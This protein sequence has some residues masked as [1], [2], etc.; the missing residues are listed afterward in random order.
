MNHVVLISEDPKFR[1][2]VERFLAWK[3][4]EVK[5]YNK[6]TEIENWEVIENSIAIVSEYQ[7]AD[8]DGFSF[9]SGLH[10]RKASAKLIL[11]VDDLSIGEECPFYYQVLDG[12]FT[13]RTFPKM[14]PRLLAPVAKL[15]V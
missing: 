12:F 6:A 7:T 8:I 11:I 9:L 10:E 15:V 1:H 13:K 3:Q 4:M 2:V 5:I 14:M